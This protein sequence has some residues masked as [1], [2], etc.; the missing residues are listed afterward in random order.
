MPFF[1][2]S[3]FDPSASPPDEGGELVELVSEEGDTVGVVSRAEAHSDTSYLHRV[4]HVLVFDDVGRL[5]VQKR[6]MNKD[7]GPGLW[8]VSVGGH[9]VPG[10]LPAEAAYREMKEELGIEFADIRF[11]YNH[12]FYGQEESEFVSTFE[13][14]YNGKVFFDHDE[15]DEIRYMDFDEIDSQLG[16]KVFTEHFEQEYVLYQELTS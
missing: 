2:G 9:V 11:L 13:C 7:V 12:V 1:P 15:I 14:T 6:S 10:E 8:D 16:K 3:R 5:L 4:V